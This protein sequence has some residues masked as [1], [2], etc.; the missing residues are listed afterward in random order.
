MAWTLRDKNG[1][2]CGCV[3]RFDPC[4]CGVPCASIACSTRGGVAEICGWPEFSTPSNPVR[5]YKR[6]TRTR[7]RGGAVFTD[8]LCV[9]PSRPT[10]L[11]LGRVVSYGAAHWDVGVVWQ[12]RA[13]YTEVRMLI[14]GV[15]ALPSL[16]GQLLV[17][18]VAL[19]GFNDT[20]GV[21]GGA[22]SDWKPAGS[23][24]II[25]CTIT[26]TFGAPPIYATGSATATAPGQDIDDF[27]S[28]HA[29]VYNGD[30][31]ALSGELGAPPALEL[32]AGSCAWGAVVD[33]SQTLRLRNGSGACCPRSPSAG[34]RLSG[35]EDR[36]EL[37]EEDTEEAAIARML[38]LS[39]WS[40]WS[41]SLPACVAAWQA[42]VGDTTGFV[43]QEAKWRATISAPA[44]P[45]G[46]PEPIP[47]VEMAVRVRFDRR[48]FG[49]GEFELFASFETTVLVAPG[50]SMVI[51]GTVPNTRGWETRVASCINK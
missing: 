3:D 44:A 28:E 10:S 12:W 32:E 25:T 47:A 34:Y 8:S 19:V 17:D 14:G 42:R 24:W 20:G 1:N 48:P 41:G 33:L 30:C 4:E 23:S 37:S 16:G 11:D 46:T 40:A 43:Y 18:G 50:A 2:C 45:P 49:A 9:D 15:A 51:E 36:D 26:G 7:S 22:L 5:R 21:F 13:D 27:F 35:G 29:L 39:G 38:A 6:Q 31:S